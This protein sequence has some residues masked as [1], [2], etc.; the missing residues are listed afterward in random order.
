V[1]PIEGCRIGECERHLLP[2]NG[3]LET[4]RLEMAIDSRDVEFGSGALIFRE[5]SPRKR[6]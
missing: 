6:K 2:K 1:A 5:E 3:E 4:T